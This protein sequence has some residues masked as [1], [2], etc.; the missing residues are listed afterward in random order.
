[1]P[2]VDDSKRWI[3]QTMSKLCTYIFCTTV[4]A[5]FESVRRNLIS[6]YWLSSKVSAAKPSEAWKQGNNWLTLS[7]KKSNTFRPPFLHF[8][9]SHFP[10]NIKRFW[11][12]LN[13]LDVLR[14]CMLNCERKL[15]FIIFFIQRIRCKTILL[16]SIMYYRLIFKASAEENN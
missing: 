15:V 2:I 11:W 1:M 14:I 12:Q 7:S 4:R 3:H 8:F 6:F 16:W 9:G 13:W 5:H 10:V